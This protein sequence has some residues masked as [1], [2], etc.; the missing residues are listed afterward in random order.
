MSFGRNLHY[1]ALFGI[2]RPEFRMVVQRASL[3]FHARGRIFEPG[4]DFLDPG[5]TFWPG[6]LFGV[7]KWSRKNEFVMAVPGISHDP[8]EF[9]CP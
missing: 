5:S 8:N 3:F 2:P 4:I 7:K 6:D 1:M 9:S